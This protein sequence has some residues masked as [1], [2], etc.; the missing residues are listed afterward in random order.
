MGLTNAL[1]TEGI[2]TFTGKQWFA[3]TIFHMLQ[4]PA[5]AGRT[6]YRRTKRERRGRSARPREEWREIEGATPAI[7][8]QALF[9]AVQ[10]RLGDPERLR[11]GR[12]QRRYDLAGH[13]R[14][15]TCEASMVGQT[16]RRPNRDYRYYRCRRAFT[17]PKHDR[18]ASRYVRANEL[19]AAV[20][21]AV[22]EVL[23]DPAIVRRELERLADQDPTERDSAKDRARL[24]EQR[25]RLR[26]LYELGEVDDADLESELSRI[27]QGLDALDSAAPTIV[28]PSPDDLDALVEQVRSWVLEHEDELPLI[29]DALQLEVRADRERAEVRGVIP[30]YAP[31]CNHADVRSMVT[32]SACRSDF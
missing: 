2:T 28:I 16:L 11:Q 21:D 5:Y 8:D 23:A 27:K 15:A 18:C 12:R 25:R 26:K 19:E 4:N 6:W 31:S 7:V 30:D 1:N 13:I 3:A 20:R 17:G 22:A 14:C 32:N 29:A 10:E 24:D 9:D